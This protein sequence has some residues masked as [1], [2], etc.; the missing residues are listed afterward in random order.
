LSGLIDGR[1]GSQPEGPADRQ[2]HHRINMSHA[3]AQGGGTTPCATAI[4]E[5]ATDSGV[6]TPDLAEQKRRSWMGYVKVRSGRRMTLPGTR[7]ITCLSPD[8]AG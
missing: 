2:R 6:N 1:R 5:R 7:S 3:V 8:L 4:I